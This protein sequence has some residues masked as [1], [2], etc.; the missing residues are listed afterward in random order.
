MTVELLHPP[1]TTA[2]IPID[3]IKVGDRRFRKEMGDIAGLAASIKEVGLLHPVVVTSSNEL[4][5]GQRRIEACRLLGWDA[6]P[7]TVVDIGRMV[8]YGEFTEHTHREPFTLSEA[9]AIKRALEPKLK[10]AAKERQLRGSSAQADAGR[11]AD[12][13]AAFVGRDR[14]TVEK[15]EAIHKAAER[16]PKK[17]GHLREELNKTDKADGA[18]KQLKAIEAAASG[19]KPKAK[20]NGKTATA[21]LTDQVL[22]DGF[23][24][25]EWTSLAAVSVAVRDYLG[26]GDLAQL[27]DD[28]FAALHQTLIEARER[29]DAFVTE[30]EAQFEA[31]QAA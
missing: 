22:I 14:R 4:V 25:L 20:P 19:A 7:V 17:F 5:A 15:A 13:V 1:K 11:A 23:T 10:E 16:D 12:K 6:V 3:A 2:T 24:D 29:F 27:D 30:V 18:Y 31:P 8:V 26:L 21:A 28:E 9:V